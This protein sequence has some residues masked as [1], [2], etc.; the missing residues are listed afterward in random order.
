MTFVL[1][2]LLL[3]GLGHGSNVVLVSICKY[4][5]AF[6]S[7]APGSSVNKQGV[8]TLNSVAWHKPTKRLASRVGYAKCKQD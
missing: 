2:H 4:S 8:C 5:I 6:A 1:L 3:V 7:L